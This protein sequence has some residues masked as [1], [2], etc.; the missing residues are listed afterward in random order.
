MFTK[1]SQYTTLYL[2][3]IINSDPKMFAYNDKIEI[4]YNYTNKPDDNSRRAFCFY[5]EEIDLTYNSARIV[6]F[7]E[8][9]QFTAIR[10]FNLKMWI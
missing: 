6:E 3:S 4:Y 8:I 1:N 7:G 2:L 5:E 10:H 9:E